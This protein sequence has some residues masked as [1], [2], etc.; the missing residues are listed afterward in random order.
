MNKMDCELLGSYLRLHSEQKELVDFIRDYTGLQTNYSI[1]RDPNICVNFK[2]NDDFHVGKNY[3]RISRSIWLDKSSVFIS[4]IERFPG[5]KLEAKIEGN[6][7]YINAYLVNKNQSV[8]K[9]MISYLISKENH[10]EFKFIGLLYYIIFVPFFYYLERFCNQ[11][12]L[13]ASAIEYEGKGII[14]AG[15]GGIGKSTFSLGTLL[16]Q[17]SKFMSD[18]LIFFDYQKI[19][20]CPEPIAL[21]DKSI[22]ILKEIANLLVPKEISFTKNRMWYQIKQEATT[23]EAIP[24]YLF[25][26]QCGNE[27]KILPL[28]KDMCINH[29]LNINLLAK[30][31]REYYILAAAFDF[32]FSRPLSPNVYFERL[33]RLLSGVDCY[34]LQFKPG[35]DIKSVFN[36]TICKII[37]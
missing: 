6:K 34:I 28:N 26:L 35:S 30:E 22:T 3:R 21:D 10:K 31:I 9:K 4:E 2:V 14:L 8:L 11:Y 24:K 16:L 12:L 29:L 15:L 32:A 13:H 7:F 33:S 5:L 27:N 20:S 1:E 36:E 25:W 18:N 17:G 19:Y 23:T 37:V